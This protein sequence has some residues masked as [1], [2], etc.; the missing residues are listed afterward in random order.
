LLLSTLLMMSAGAG[1]TQAQNCEALLELKIPDTKIVL[2]QTVSEGEFTPPGGK[3]ISHLPAFCRVAGVSKPTT[4]SDI[5][6]EV[7]LPMAGWNGKFRGVGNGGFAGAIDYQQLGSAI[8]HGYASAS[9][10]TGHGTQGGVDASWAL[11]HPEKIIDFG[12]RAIHV[13]AV[14]AKMIIAASYGSPAKR[15][16]FSSCSNGGRQA[17]MEAQRFPEDYD[18][19]IAGAPASYWTHLL[20]NAAWDVQALLQQAES[21][22]PAAKLPAIQAA[23]LA[24]CDAMDGVKDSVIEDPSRCHFDTSVLL[25]KGKENDACLTG[26]QVAALNKLYAGGRTSTGKL[27]FPGYSPGGEAEPNAWALWITGPGPEK[28]LM[29]LFATQFFKNMVFGDPQW[30]FRRFNVGRDVAAADEKM[31]RYLNANDPDLLRFQ[32]RGGKLILYHG[33]SD[34]AIAATATIDYYR[35]VTAKMGAAQ[36]AKFVRLFMV[37]GMEHC[38]GG[39]GPDDFGQAGAGSGDE[40]HSINTQ[41]E[42]WI[43]NGAAPNSVIASKHDKAGRVTRTRPLCAY[44]EVAKYKG[45]GSTDSADNF[46]CAAQGGGAQG[47]G[48]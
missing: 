28:S 31:A 48:Q 33:W 27:V 2:A 47:L 46:V 41:L 32:K 44:P 38:V 45:T 43:E 21:Y 12:Y 40:R 18:G 3:I 11:G 26:A 37:P 29:Y 8:A 22:I 10:N 35:R 6:F 1:I 39:E 34:A 9:T 16:Y 4:D 30:D 20:A 7:W 5:E 36:T 19:I 14:N 23:A 42:H 17:L 15:S 13:T 24:A 25:C